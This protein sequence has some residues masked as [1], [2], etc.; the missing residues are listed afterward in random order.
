MDPLAQF[1]ALK[2]H[3]N[4]KMTVGPRQSAWSHRRFS[5]FEFDVGAPLLHGW[6]DR[7][8]VVIAVGDDD[9]TRT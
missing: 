1:S 8:E 4:V 7:N 9:T 2:S 6:L 3:G 5:Y